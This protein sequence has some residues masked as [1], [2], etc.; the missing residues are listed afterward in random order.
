MKTFFSRP[1]ASISLLGMVTF[2]LLGLAAA[3]TH[4]QTLTLKSGDG[5][6][7]SGAGTV[8]TI[9][10][11]PVANTTSTYST[12]AGNNKAV[13]TNGT[14]TFTLQN[15]GTLS[16]GGL[17]SVGLYALG[18]G[19]VT[20]TGG[21]IS[22][23]QNSYGL[24]TNSGS[25]ITISGG[26]ISAGTNG[27]GLAALG[28]GAVTVSGGSITTG[29]NSI[30]LYAANG[31]AATIIGGTFSAGQ[32]GYGLYTYQGTLNLFSKGDSPFLIDGVAMN[33]ITLDAN[34]Y[35]SGTHTIS[36]ILENDDVLNT[37][38]I[39]SGTVNLNIG[40]PPA[41]VPEASTTVSLGVLLM[42]G[43]GGILVARKK[44]A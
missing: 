34:K 32:G 31:G 43:V 44:A 17:Y 1:D 14:S 7:V 21:S 19:A 22:V 13:V 37:T 2:A 26:S 10:G 25:A 15:G 24:F 42:L 30:G 18:F 6:T 36:G 11:K 28:F 9:G 38:F 8:G 5:V 4:A 23:G 12:V 27:T 40:T 16:T 39:D 3:P 20:M 41:A 29:L 35:T 33:N